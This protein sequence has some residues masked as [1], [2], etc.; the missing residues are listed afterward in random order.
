MDTQLPT[1][2]LVVE[3]QVQSFKGIVTLLLI[4]REPN[5]SAFSYSI[6]EKGQ[7]APSIQGR[8]GFSSWYCE[9]YPNF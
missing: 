3:R 9:N 8:G 2:P 7:K 5:N 6:T 1:D 4:I